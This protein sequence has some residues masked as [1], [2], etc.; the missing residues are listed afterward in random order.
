MQGL[1]SATEEEAGYCCKG[2][3]VHRCDGAEITVCRGQLWESL[4]E[5]NVIVVYVEN[6][7]E[8]QRA[9]GQGEH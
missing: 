1:K 8:G 9:E 5:S 7:H 3:S 2:M 4:K 6:G